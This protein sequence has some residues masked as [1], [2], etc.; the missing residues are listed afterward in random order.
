VP[1]VSIVLATYND[2]AFLPP[3]LESLLGQTFRDFELIVVDDGSTDHTPALLDGFKDPRLRVLR[4][5]RNLGLAASLNRGAAI[6]TGKYIARQDADTMSLPNRLEVQVDYLDRHPDVVVVGTSVMAMDEA[7]KVGGLW[8]PPPT[9]ID[10]KWTLLFRTPFVHPSVVMRADALAKAGFYSEEGEFCYVEDYE[11]WTRLC[12][13][14]ICVN[15]HHPLLNFT[16]RPGSVCGRHADPQQ[17]QIEDVSRRAMAGMIGSEWTP[18]FW[19]AVQKFLY[20]RAAE[21]GRWD[22][23]ELQLAISALERLY[24]AFSRSYDFPPVE[25]RRHKK[26]VL[27]LWGRH[28][29]AL[30]MKGN[31]R[32]DFRCRASFMAK[33]TALLSKAAYFSMG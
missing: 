21:Q 6:A 26:Q 9:D 33:G 1:L 17:R 4:N 25:L 14:G 11:L 18:D 15:L 28:C 23:P 30:G 7:G 16:C 5:P 29:L 8:M 10:V 2:A 24:V 13:V 19:P 3:S 31:G 27:T 22:A 32:R 20:S 12:P